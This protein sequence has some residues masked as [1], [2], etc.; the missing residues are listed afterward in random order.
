M[1]ECEDTKNMFRLAIY[2]QGAADG[3]VGSVVGLLL[4]STVGSVVG[5]LDGMV[6]GLVVG[7]MDGSIVGSMVG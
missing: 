1:I 3:C 7:S 4:G 6:V 5:L 2:I